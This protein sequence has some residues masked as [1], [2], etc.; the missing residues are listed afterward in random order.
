MNTIFKKIVI[1]FGLALAM[2]FG[3]TLNFSLSKAP[4]IQHQLTMERVLN[5]PLAT[6][7]YQL[8]RLSLRGY[9]ESQAKMSDHAAKTQADCVPTAAQ[10]AIVNG[11]VFSPLWDPVMACLF[12]ASAKVYNDIT[13]TFTTNGVDPT[14]DASDVAVGTTGL[15]YTSEA[16]T[17]TGY[18][19]HIVVARGTSICIDL[20]FATNTT[21]AKGI[22]LLNS[23]HCNGATFNA[24]TGAAAIAMIFD[25]KHDDSTSQ[26]IETVYVGNQV[27]EATFDVTAQAE[28]NP[29]S[30]ASDEI[31]YMKIAVAGAT[32]PT[33]VAHVRRINQGTM[34]G[35]LAQEN[36][37]MLANGKT[38][39]DML[40]YIEGAPV[41]LNA[42]LSLASAVTDGSVLGGP[43]G[44]VY[45]QCVNTGTNTVNV[46][47]NLGGH[48]TTRLDLL[49]YIIDGHED[50]CTTAGY[51]WGNFP[52][53]P[54]QLMTGI[55]GYPNWQ[56]GSGAGAPTVTVTKKAGEYMGMVA[57]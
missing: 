46:D 35:A 42:P 1:T 23:L 34:T 43:F 57:Y 56:T 37:G 41:T 28:Y 2:I 11:G 29:T 18:T 25:L 16:S 8:Q 40:I 54:D 36:L 4:V 19:R 27:T 13:T 32:A 6:L 9:N 53:S 15:T 3:P 44:G 26:S 10:L 45:V 52:V 22:L 38:G 33:T 39:G 21:G 48:S 24:T 14:V 50:A 30:K 17:V 47:T 55:T 51:I 49:T 31:F 5:T 20:N 7:G 12:M